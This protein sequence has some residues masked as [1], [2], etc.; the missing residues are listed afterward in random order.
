MNAWE[1]LVYY[2]NDVFSNNYK[3]YRTIYRQDILGISRSPW[4][5]DNYRRLLELGGYLKTIRPGVYQVVRRV[6]YTLGK[7]QLMWKVYPECMKREKQSR[8]KYY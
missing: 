5:I 7:R 2:I 6:P 3:E 1:R 8:K 4:T